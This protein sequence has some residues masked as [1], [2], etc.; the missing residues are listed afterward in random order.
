[1]SDQIGKSIAG[2]Q[3]VEVIDDT[4]RALVYKGVKSTENRYV[5]VKV[6]QPGISTDQAAVQ[7]FK[8]YAQLA[9]SMQH[10]NILPVLDSGQVDGSD[11]L[12]TPFMENLS[13]ANHLSSYADLN[14]AQTLIGAIVPGL[15]YIYNHGIIHGNLRP[16]NTILDAQGKPLL[17]DFG[18]ALRQGEMPTPYNSPEQ[19]QGGVVDQRTDVFALGVLSY[20][21]LAGQTPVSGIAPSIRAIRPDVP[22]GVEQVILKAMAPGPDQRYQTPG[23]FH[24]AL[25]NALL[26]APAPAAAQAPV[27]Q[28]QAPPQKGTNWMGIALGALLV[29]VLCLGAALVGPKLMEYLNPQ[30]TQPAAVQPI[31]PPADQ[32]AEERPTR[33]PITLPTR[34]PEQP[35]EQPSAEQLP[36]GDEGGGT[37]GLNIC[38]SL[39]L[40]GGFVFM[41]GAFKLRRRKRS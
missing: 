28:P 3:I 17:A 5:A 25:K 26:P 38:S 29:I 11:Y 19:A 39:G 40:A 27:A 34:P 13:V 23:E 7:S 36:A 20:T 33:E 9:A 15:E 6:L 21:I 35:P 1:M 30:A 31:E 2:Y 4:G 10:P 16:S 32:P 24:I 22:Q 12:V 14:Q 37:Q 8:Q 18:I 41:G